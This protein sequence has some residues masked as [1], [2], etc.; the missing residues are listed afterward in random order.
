MPFE[1]ERKFLPKDPDWR[2]TGPCHVL[3]QGFFWL[4]EDSR[5]EVS[6]KKERGLFRLTPQGQSQSFE[7]VL[8]E[9]DALALGDLTTPHFSKH[10]Y[11]RIRESD[12]TRYRLTLKGP[13]ADNA[14]HIRPEFEYDINA[15]EGRALLA[16]CAEN[17]ILKRRYPLPYQGYT[18]EIDVFDGLHTGLV[19]CEV[20]MQSADENPPRPDFIGREVTSEKAYRNVT[21]ARSQKIPEIPCA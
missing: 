11:A 20:E 14:Q 10:W 17:H 9:A 7:F 4:D 12:G 8:P 15:E 16:L 21:L 19:L 1:I 2:P 13:S 18:W 3:R 5:G 6:C